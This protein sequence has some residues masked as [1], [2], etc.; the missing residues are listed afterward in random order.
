MPRPALR[1]GRGP[2]RRSR[3]PGGCPLRPE[4]VRARTQ[5]KLQANAEAVPRGTHVIDKKGLENASPTPNSGPDRPVR[6]SPG[7][8][9]TDAPALS[10]LAGTKGYA[11]CRKSGA[12][13]CYIRVTAPQNVRRQGDSPGKPRGCGREAIGPLRPVGEV[14]RMR[15]IREARSGRGRI[16]CGLV[17]TEPGPKGRPCRPSGVA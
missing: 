16:I 5:R 10:N 12:G 3:R 9:H 13:G 7:R 8:P 15:Y 11:R 2:R 14:L 4:N 1:P 17:P 6:R